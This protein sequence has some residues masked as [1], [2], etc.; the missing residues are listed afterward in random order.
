MTQQKE[1]RAGVVSEPPE[2][3]DAPDAEAALAYEAPFLI[4]KLVKDRIAETSGEAQVLF[5]EVKRFLLLVRTDRHVVWDMYSRRVDEVWHQ[6]VL[7]TREYIDFCFRCFGSYVQHSPGVASRPSDAEAEAKEDATCF[8]DFARRY[9]ELYGTPL[10]DVW[11]DARSVTP[12]RRI[13][14]DNAGKMSVQVEDGQ[15]DLVNDGAL[16]LSI[17]GPAR[18]ALDFVAATGAF[19]VRELPGELTEEEKVALATVL[20]EQGIVRV[21]P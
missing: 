19:Y 15:V 6:F 5:S 14:N 2:T 20:V 18:R 1:I 17:R 4:E 21:A 16:V 7:F 8:H 13:L 10:P 12:R 9:E 3:S 11:Y